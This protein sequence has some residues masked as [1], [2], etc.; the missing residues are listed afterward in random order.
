MRESIVEYAHTT[1]G[2][3]DG[4]YV[5][6]LT[7]GSFSAVNVLV[8]YVKCLTNTVMRNLQKEHKINSHKYGGREGERERSIVI[9]SVLSV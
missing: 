8:E 5:T 9:T 6:E 4:V 7:L 3:C 2:C 1:C